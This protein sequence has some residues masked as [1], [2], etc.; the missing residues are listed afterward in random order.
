[1][2]A[3]FQ[4]NNL[5]LV[6]F[7][8]LLSLTVTSNAIADRVGDGP[9]IVTTKNNNLC[10][11]VDKY[12]PKGSIFQSRSIARK[13]LALQSIGVLKYQG[14]AIWSIY[15]P[16]QNIGNEFILKS[17]QC[18][19]Y[20]IILKNYKTFKETKSLSTGKFTVVISGI[21]LQENR[22]AK[23]LTSFNL[24]ITDGQLNLID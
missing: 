21:D 18:L 23:F 19:E 6:L 16:T 14:D 9:V 24:K 2:L 4:R 7:T 13:G 10:F 20:G 11:A 1:M 8:F 12:K 3:I 5:R 15:V 17:E 22:T